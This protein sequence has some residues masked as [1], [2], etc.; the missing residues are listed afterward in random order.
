MLELQVV[1][2]TLVSRFKFSPGPELAKE[3]KLAAAT[4]QT[5]VAAIHALAGVHVTLQPLSGVM[6]LAVEPR[7]GSV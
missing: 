5:K 7:A 6:E 3:L 4:G 1:V 2:A